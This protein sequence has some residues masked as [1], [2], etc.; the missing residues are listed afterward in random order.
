MLFVIKCVPLTN[1]LNYKITINIYIIIIVIIVG[2]VLLLV[3]SLSV[4]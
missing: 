3:S 2:V 4:C 1:M